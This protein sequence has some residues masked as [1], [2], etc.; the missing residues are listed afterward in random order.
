MA[1][2]SKSCKNIKCSLAF[3]DKAKGG[4]IV[5]PPPITCWEDGSAMFNRLQHKND[6]SAKF[7]KWEFE[8]KEGWFP[9]RVLT[10]YL[11]EAE[12]R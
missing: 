7:V 1:I 2:S 6:G 10:S 11:V 3:F 5:P 12:R 4:K 9:Y 8:I